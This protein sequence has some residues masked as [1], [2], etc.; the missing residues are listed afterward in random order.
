MVLVLFTVHSLPNAREAK[1]SYEVVAIVMQISSNLA[2]LNHRPPKGAGLPP[3]SQRA[4]I[5][6]VLL[7]RYATSSE[8][9][10]TNLTH[11]EGRS[12]TA[13]HPLMLDS[14]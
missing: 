8:Q 14:V 6:L 4:E 12:S 9:R 5:F 1:L 3:R 7:N 13:V 10:L 11:F 2:M